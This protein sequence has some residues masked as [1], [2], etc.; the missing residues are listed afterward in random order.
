MMPYV[1]GLD[2]S[3][4]D[5]ATF[6]DLGRTTLRL[7]EWGDPLAPPVVAVHG[8][9]DHGR[10]YDGLAPQ[11]AARG[12]HVVAV[13]LRGHGD[14][15]RLGDSGSCWLAWNLDLASLLRRL[16]PPVGL[17]GH[18]LGGGQVLSVASAFPDLVRW[19]LNMDGLGPAPEMMIVEDHAAHAAQ[20]LAEAESVWSKPQREYA[21]LDE[22][23]ARRKQLNLRLP[24]EWAFHLSQHGSTAGPNGGL[25]WKSDPVMRIGVPGPWGEAYLQAQYGRIRCPVAVLTGSEHDTWSDLP[26]DIVAARVR[27]I[28]AATHDRV[29]GA[30]HYIHLEQPD[31]VLGHLDALVRR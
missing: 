3:E 13:D 25:V 21:S 7:W 28:P 12:F 19:V 26:A 31:A 18:S 2:L 14:S 6:A 22:L 30:G 20:W 17:I 8:G 24:Y 1:P 15:G 27:S 23:A 10:M 29:E 5:R 16:G 11:V 4:P 9:W